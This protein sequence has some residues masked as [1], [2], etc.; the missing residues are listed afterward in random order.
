MKFLP[1][2]LLLWIL[3]FSVLATEIP[4]RIEIS[5]S[6]KTDV[7]EGE[8]TEVMEMKKHTD[9]GYRYTINSK[10]QA[11]G[12]YKLIEPNSIVRRSEGIIT[13]QGLQPFR[14][15]ENAAKRT[16]SGDI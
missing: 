11:T 10:A 9:D 5:Y 6:V 2:I 13:K 7:G 16:Q 8:I 15:Y 12:V 14:A 3:S 1:P 4:S